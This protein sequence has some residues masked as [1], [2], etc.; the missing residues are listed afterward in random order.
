MEALRRKDNAET[1]RARRFAETA[2]AGVTFGWE[3]V[4]RAVDGGGGIQ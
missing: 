1:Q 3:L 2:T 4:D